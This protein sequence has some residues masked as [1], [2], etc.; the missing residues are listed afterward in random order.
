MKST[1][2]LT[3][4]FLGLALPAI[5]FAASHED[6]AKSHTSPTPRASTMHDMAM[7]PTHNLRG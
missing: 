1:A 2:F 7:T 6:A 3:L 4:V 5:S